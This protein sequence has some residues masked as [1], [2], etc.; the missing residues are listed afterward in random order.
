MTSVSSTS[1]YELVPPPA[2]NTVARP[3]TLGACQVRLQESMLFVPIATRVNFCAMKLTSFVALE[4]LSIP[5]VLGPCASTARRKPEAARSRASSQL[6]VRRTPLSRTSGSVSRAYFIGIAF[7]LSLAVLI[8]TTALRACQNGGIATA[9][10]RTPGRAGPEW[11]Q[12]DDR[13]PT[14]PRRA[15][16]RHVDQASARRR[17]G[18][19]GGRG[20]SRD[21][22]RRRAAR[23]DHA[24][25]RARRGARAGVPLHRGPDRRTA[26]R[27][28]D[29]RPGGEHDR[30]RGTLVPRPGHP[31]L[32]HDLVVRRVRQGRT[33]GG[34]R[35]RAAR[36]ARAGDRSRAARH[37]ARPPAPADV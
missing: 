4:Q 9:D 30:G 32:L 33:R 19:R 29:R 21:P 12:I 10:R 14:H 18:F 5:Y 35:A 13:R 36:R 22:R 3:T 16:P 34:R 23:G 20:A 6:A 31:P 7:P 1:R 17:G 25:A 11:T 28:L 26:P 15:R 8:V 24:H 2:P 37:A 27:R